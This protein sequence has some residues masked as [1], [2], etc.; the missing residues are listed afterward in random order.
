MKITIFTEGKWDGTFIHDYLDFL[1]GENVIKSLEIEFVSTGGWTN[2]EASLPKFQETTDAG[3]K[4]LVLFD[5]DYVKTHGGFPNRF[6]DITQK[7]AELNIQFELFLFPNNSDNGIFEDLLE[8]IVHENHRGV[9]ECFHNYEQCIAVLNHAN[10]T[11][12]YNEPIQK[13][14][15]FAFMETVATSKEFQESKKKS[16]W[17][18]ANS[19]YWN[20]SSTAILQLKEFLERHITT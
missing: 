13:S 5:A 11:L 19:N 10:P 2:I 17:C 3:G 12:H 4:N 9:L 1:F 14:K 6:A 8:E 20:L 16:N 18:Y 7:K 15:I